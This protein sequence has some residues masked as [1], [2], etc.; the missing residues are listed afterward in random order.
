MSPVFVVLSS[1][2]VLGYG[3]PVEA[4]LVQGMEEDY[5][6]EELLVAV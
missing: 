1:L 4:D 6:K 3:C 2:T 5:R